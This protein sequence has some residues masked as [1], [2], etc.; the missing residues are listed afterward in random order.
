MQIT[1]N[2]RT[3]VSCIYSNNTISRDP[4]P[5]FDLQTTLFLYFSSVTSTIYNFEKIMKIML[6][7]Y[8][9]N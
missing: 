8:K 4:V 6:V 5:K 3:S 2:D 9:R 7:Y 1:S